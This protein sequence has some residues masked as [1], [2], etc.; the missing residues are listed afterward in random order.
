MDETPTIPLSKNIPLTGSLL[1]LDNPL[2]FTGKYGSSSVSGP[3]SMHSAFSVVRGSISTY[4]SSA[5]NMRGT[6][7]LVLQSQYAF[8]SSGMY[9]KYRCYAHGWNNP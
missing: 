8:G 1:Y 3:Y 4:G 6:T 5:E 9:M 2:G 7:Y